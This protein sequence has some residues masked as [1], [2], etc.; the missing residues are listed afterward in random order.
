MS[1]NNLIIGLI[2]GIGIALLIVYLIKQS[3]KGSIVE[4]KRDASG[5]ITEILEHT[6]W[7][8]H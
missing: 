6:I 1:D 8:K 2:A 4:L 3:N 7:V 5:N